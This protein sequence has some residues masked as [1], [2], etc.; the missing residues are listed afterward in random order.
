[1][2]V[3]FNGKQAGPFELIGGS[4]QGS[5]IGS[6]DN[7]EQLMID[8]ED[9]YQY[10]DDLALLELIILADVLIQYNFRA[11]AVSDIAIGQR[12][13]PPLATKSQMFHDG[14]SNWTQQNLM[15]L[16]S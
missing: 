10:I 3:K 2:K 11:H 1:M 7:T 6:H 15:E 9:N 8:E 13:L 12:S 14:I 4:P 5:I 16:N